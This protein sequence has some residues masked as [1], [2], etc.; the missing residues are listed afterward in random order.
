M[1]RKLQRRVRTIVEFCGVVDNE[2]IDNPRALTTLK[3]KDKDVLIG[4]WRLVSFD[5]ERFMQITFHDNRNNLLGQKELGKIIELYPVSHNANVR[6]IGWSTDTLLKIDFRLL[7]GK[8]FIESGLEVL[9]EVLTAFNVERSVA[10][11]YLRGFHIIQETEVWWHN[12]WVGFGQ[13]L[14]LTLPV[15]L[16]E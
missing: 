15:L 6:A 10:K 13:Y 11:E 9:L 5:N 3:H 1:S 7:N 4:C 2:I 16:E 14:R 12:E 8:G